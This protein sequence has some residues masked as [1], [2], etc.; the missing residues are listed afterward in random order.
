MKI[1]FA[2]PSKTSGLDSVLSTT[3]S[4]LTDRKRKRRHLPLKKVSE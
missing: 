1:S 4:D 3:M 2:S